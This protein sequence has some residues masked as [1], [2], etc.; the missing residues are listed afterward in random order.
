MGLTRALV[1]DLL[2]PESALTAAAVPTTVR[3]ASAQVV[4]LEVEIRGNMALVRNQAL[5]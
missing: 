5:K 1:A 4:N 3:R 2:I